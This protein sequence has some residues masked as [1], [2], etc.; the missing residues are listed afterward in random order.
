[1]TKLGM[2]R[3]LTELPIFV[4][5]IFKYKHAGVKSVHPTETIFSVCLRILLDDA[6]LTVALIELR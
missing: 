2:W 5:D 1:M 6:V 3:P 4:H